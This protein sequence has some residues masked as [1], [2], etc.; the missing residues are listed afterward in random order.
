M[1]GPSSS[2]WTTTG[3]LSLAAGAIQWATK[4][5]NSSG[6]LLATFERQ[7]AR[8]HARPGPARPP[9][10]SRR[11]PGR[12]PRA[13]ACAS[14]PAGGSPGSRSRRSA[15]ASGGSSRAGL[16]SADGEIVRRVD[17]LARLAV[18][19]RVHPHRLGEEAAEELEGDRVGARAVAEQ[20]VFRPEAQLAVRVVVD[21]LDHVR[22]RHRR[23]DVGPGGH[24]PWRARSAARS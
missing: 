14:R 8:R 5:G 24:A 6:V 2:E 19:D 10:G 4:S 12:W 20:R 16:S 22:R 7:A 3:S 23:R 17:D 13:R 15:L 21:P 11:R 9:P 18:L 1:L